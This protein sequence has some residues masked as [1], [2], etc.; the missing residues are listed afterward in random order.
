MD[1]MKILTDDR[2]PYSNIGIK[3]ICRNAKDIH[4]YRIWGM[5]T[6]ILEV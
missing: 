6:T 2:D 4:Y 3:L 1:A 5:N